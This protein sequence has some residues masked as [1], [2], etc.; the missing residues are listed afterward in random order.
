MKHPGRDGVGCY[1]HR[2]FPQCRAVAD[3]MVDAR[4]V[5]LA[6]GGGLSGGT[7]DLDGPEAVPHVPQ[8]DDQVPLVHAEI[9][10]GRPIEAFQ[11]EVLVVLL[12]RSGLI[13]GHQGAAVGPRRQV[14]ADPLHHARSRHVAEGAERRARHGIESFEAAP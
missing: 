8:G 6:V 13:P 7:D 12:Q 10:A 2:S 9:P 1:D 14:R 5:A 3:N 11:P 4:L